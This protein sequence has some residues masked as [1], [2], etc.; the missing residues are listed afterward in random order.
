MVTLSVFTGACSTSYKEMY[1]TLKEYKDEPYFSYSFAFKYKGEKYFF[2]RKR[3]KEKDF[4]CY[5]YLG[6]KNEK[7]AYVFP[8][9]I[10]YKIKGVY[11]NNDSPEEIKEL[12]LK[13]ARSERK[14]PDKCFKHGSNP[15]GGNYGQ[16]LGIAVMLF[17]ITISFA[18]YEATNRIIHKNLTQSMPLGISFDNVPNSVKERWTKKKRG[19]YEY[20]EFKRKDLGAIFYFKDGHLDAWSQFRPD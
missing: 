10:F 11:K 17:P 2:F 18:L 19:K 8:S 3:F 1:P 6:F 9:S 5:L 7:L 16:G 4:K 12:I 20:Y 15:Y 14:D 13:Y